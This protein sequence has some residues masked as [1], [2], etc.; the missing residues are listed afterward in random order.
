MSFRLT[1]S[2]VWQQVHT[3]SLCET[4]NLQRSRSMVHDCMQWHTSSPASRAPSS[5]PQ[6]TTAP[7]VDPPAS[8]WQQESS[9]SCLD[10]KQ[11]QGWEEIKQSR[12]SDIEKHV[13]IN[14]EPVTRAQV[15]PSVRCA[16]STSALG[17]VVTC[18]K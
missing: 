5:S 18:Y 17:W 1:Y 7:S 15:P 12:Y 13:R 6:G 9:F 4:R 2:K 16:N 11:K 8:S 14:V 10:K 3:V